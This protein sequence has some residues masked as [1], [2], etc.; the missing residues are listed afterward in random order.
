MATGKIV[1]MSPVEAKR[2]RMAEEQVEVL[3]RSNSVLR[4]DSL[5]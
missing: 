2:L 3:E 1:E 5:L 4:Y